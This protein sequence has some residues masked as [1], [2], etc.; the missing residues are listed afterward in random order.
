MELYFPPFSG[1][2]EAGVLSVMCANN[3]VNGEYVCENN[4]TENTMLRTWGGFKGWVCSDYDGTRS[5]IR[6]ANGGLDIA[7]PGPPARPD[8]F[9]GMLADAVKAGTVSEATITQKAVRVVY[10]LAKVGALDTKNN[11]TA[12]MDVTSPEHE[13]LARK[14]ASA[15]CILLKNAPAGGTKGAPLLPLD[16][17]KVKSIAV[18]GDAGNKGAIFGGDGSGKV[19]PKNGSAISI[20]DALRSRAGLHVTHAT[21][22]PS[23]GD[24]AALAKA[25]D[26]V[27]VVLAQSSTEGHDRTNLSLAQAELVPLVSVRSPQPRIFI[28]LK[29]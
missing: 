6:A 18:I 7:M 15:S 4:F 17:S 25:A 9:G 13:A 5:T 22:F 8:F 21:G 12:D 14:L 2:V 24:P 19:V 29:S 16:A 10:S 26:V 20:Y 23:G 1:A 28:T 11:N 3:L 27:I